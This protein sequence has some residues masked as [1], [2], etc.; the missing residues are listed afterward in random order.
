[1]RSQKNK[2]DSLHILEGHSTSE[3][4]LHNPQRLNSDLVRESKGI[5]NL[6]CVCLPLIHA[7][8]SLIRG[9]PHYPALVIR[10]LPRSVVVA[11]LTTASDRNADENHSVRRRRGLFPAS[12]L[13]MVAWPNSLSDITRISGCSSSFFDTALRNSHWQKLRDSRIAYL[14]VVSPPPPPSAFAQVCTQP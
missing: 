5:H 4:D 2:K 6:R 1:M 9:F 10:R 14:G 11:V 7:F 13:T 12:L 8:H 3:G